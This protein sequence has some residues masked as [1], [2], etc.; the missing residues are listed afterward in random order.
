MEAIELNLKTDENGILNIPNKFPK[1]AEMKVIVLYEEE[2]NEE[3]EW[4]EMLNTNPALDFL[5][6]E[7][8]IYTLDDGKPI[9]YEG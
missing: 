3:E 1:K 9:E 2:M 8:N 4:L 5:K 6:D 7:E